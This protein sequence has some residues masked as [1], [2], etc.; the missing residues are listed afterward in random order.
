MRGG[1]AGAIEKSAEKIDN[2]RKIFDAVKR[3]ESNDYL[4]RDGVLYRDIEG[5]IRIVVPTVMRRQVI[6]RA[7]EQGHFG[8]SKTEA[9]LKR[10]YWIPRLH[11]EVEKVTKNCIACILAE[12]KRGKSEDFLNPIEKGSVSLDTFPIDYLGPLLSTRKDYMH[13]FVVVDT[14]F[15]IRVAVCDQNSERKRS[16]V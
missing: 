7:Y 2:L 3:A 1:S 11:A 8:I 5:D 13:I 12:R 10:D 15:E 14:I 4:I 16:N 6:R 9:L